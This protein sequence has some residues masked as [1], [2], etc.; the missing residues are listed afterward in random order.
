MLV[1]RIGSG[2]GSAIDVKFENNSVNALLADKL[3]SNICS[4]MF[5]ILL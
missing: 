1:I 2:T 4:K 3:L 5:Q